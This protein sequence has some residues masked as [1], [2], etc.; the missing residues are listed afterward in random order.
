MEIP[1]DV[2]GARLRKTGSNACTRHELIVQTLA[3]SC[4]QKSTKLTHG[5]SAYDARG[6]SPTQPNGAHSHQTSIQGQKHAQKG[7]K[8]WRCTQQ[9][10]LSCCGINGSIQWDV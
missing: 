10:V 1:H 5:Y 8:G 9:H 4:H 7:Q 2:K 3:K 6:S